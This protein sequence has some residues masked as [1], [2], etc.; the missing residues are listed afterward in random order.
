[1]QLRR[2]KY[3]DV[4]SG[5][6]SE[7][8]SPS[9]MSCDLHEL[10]SS[11]MSSESDLQDTEED[12]QPQCIDTFDSDV[13]LKPSSYVLPCD[14]DSELPSGDVEDTM[15]YCCMNGDLH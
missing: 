5:E 9:P 4:T 7:M 14:A 13:F 12:D 2:Q 1:V 11:P 3:K 6:S 15:A 8:T 10:T